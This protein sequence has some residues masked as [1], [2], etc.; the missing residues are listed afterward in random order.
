VIGIRL[1]LLTLAEMVDYYR[2]L[3]KIVQVSETVELADG[4]ALPLHSA[5]RLAFPRIVKNLSRLSR[6]RRHSLQQRFR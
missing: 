4:A 5:E 2:R 3:T 1:I 6:E